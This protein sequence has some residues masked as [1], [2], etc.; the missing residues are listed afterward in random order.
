MT[1]LAIESELNRATKSLKDD[2]ELDNENFN[3]DIL[4]AAIINKGATFEPL[5]ADPDY[6]YIMNRYFWLKWNRTFN[7]WFNAFDIEYNPLD[8]YDRHEEI[9]D[10]T[11]DEGSETSSSSR[12]YDGTS[13]NTS[14]NSSSGDSETTNTVS[15]YDSSTY[16]PHDKSVNDNS[17]RE[18]GSSSTDDHNEESA[19]GTTN[20]TFEREQTHMAHIWGNIGVTTSSAML[21]EFLSI[22]EWN[23]YE[24]I[25]DIYCREM[26]ITVF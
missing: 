14:S 4:L 24:H 1:I 25:A 26:L 3:P 21:K 23:C 11:N 20:N 19:S 22:R 17:S 12:E 6:F 5:Y 9:T 15:A 13:E 2:W 18:S 16:Q 8:N 10:I 7:E